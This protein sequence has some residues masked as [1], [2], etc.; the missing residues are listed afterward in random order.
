MAVTIKHIAKEV[1]L[2]W[3]TVSRILNNRGSAFRAETC[4]RVFEAAERLGYRRN[5]A[6]VA[7]KSRNLGQIAVIIPLWP[8]LTTPTP[9][10]IEE[11]IGINTE[12]L[13]SSYVMAVVPMMITSE[14][15][16]FNARVFRDLLFDGVIAVDIIPPSL[17]EPVK[18]LTPV[19]VWANT[20]VWQPTLC[21]RRDEVYSGQ[22]AVEGLR[23]AGYQRMVY[24]RRRKK[25]HYSVLDRL[26]G[27][28]A[29]AAAC[30]VEVEVIDV[31]DQFQLGDAPDRIAALPSDVAVLTSD[32]TVL[33]ALQLELG[34]RRVRI[35]VDLSVACLDDAPD[36]AV[37]GFYAARVQFSRV[38]LGR[39]A[40]RMLLN[41]LDGD[42]SVDSVQMRGTWMEGTTLVRRSQEAAR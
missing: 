22:V 16:Q 1:G 15:N 4:E 12:L 39:Q 14:M 17:R 9:Q 6:A 36:L 35:G 30:G 24:L 27:V 20:D 19:C 2:T 34:I 3:P 8:D 5:G 18:N 42:K 23:R 25:D 32:V 10:I 41:A 40:A 37:C 21:V 33:R 7:M 26:A 38:E 31:V 11:V 13:S 29:G 28:H